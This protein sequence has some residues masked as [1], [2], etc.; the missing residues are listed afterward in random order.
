MELGR[1]VHLSLKE[2]YQLHVRGEFPD[3]LQHLTLTKL[4]ELYRNAE[5]DASEEVF[6]DAVER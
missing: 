2:I 6:G 3:H 1:I 5:D 4:V